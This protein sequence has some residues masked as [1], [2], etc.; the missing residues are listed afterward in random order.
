MIG[1]V[2]ATLKISGFKKLQ[3]DA[4]R[5]AKS[6]DNLAK[7]LDEASAGFKAMGVAA[8][9]AFAGIALG[10][11]K[12]VK[13][14]GEQIR[15]ERSL[16]MAFS[17]LGDGAAAASQE[18]RELAASLQQTTTFGDEATI[19]AAAFLRIQGMTKDQIKNALPVIQDFA[20]VTGQDL[21]RAS[22]LAGRAMTGSVKVLERYIG[23]I[24][25]STAATINSLG[26][27]E[28]AAAVAELLQQKV[29]GQAQVLRQSGVGAMQAYSNAIGDLFEEMGRIIDQPVRD[30]FESSTKS[31]ETMTKALGSL[32]PWAKETLVTVGKFAL[33]FSGAAAAIAAAALALPQMVAGLKMMA[34]AWGVVKA[35]IVAALAPM[36][37]FV[38]VAAVMVTAIAGLRKTWADFGDAFLFHAK[39]MFA[40]VLDVV[41]IW[42]RNVSKFFARVL[43]R[44]LGGIRKMINGLGQLAFA[45]GMEDLAKDIKAF[46]NISFD[47]DLGLL[48]DAAKAASD[49]A[50]TAFT[51]IGDGASSAGN[52]LAKAFGGAFD[53]VKAGFD[54]L[55]KDIAGVL[56]V[57]PMT[58]A[59]TGAAA[60]GAGA[61]RRGAD[62]GAGAG[63][64]KAAAKAR[65]D[66]E[67]LELEA[68]KKNVAAFE[69]RAKQDQMAL[70]AF[71]SNLV[72]RLELEAEA[73]DRLARHIEA[74]DAKLGATVGAI[75]AT[76]Q[77]NL[78]ALATNF[79][80]AL[81]PA[82]Q[83]L[84][85]FGVSLLNASAGGRELQESLKGLFASLAEVVSPVARAFVPLVEALRPIVPVLTQLFNMLLTLSFLE[86]AI[87]IVATVIEVLAG[88]LQTLV[89]AFR[90]L[91]IELLRFVQFITFG[92]I[93]FTR[94][95]AEL[96]A[97]NEALMRPTR[98]AAE[99]MERVAGA[100]DKATQSFE[101][102]NVPSGFKINRAAF[103]A[104]QGIAPGMA[105]DFISR[106]GQAVQRFSPGDTIV[107]FNGDG[108]LGGGGT[109]Y[110]IGEVII[111]G[112]D[113]PEDF[114]EKIS[115]AVRFE[116][117]RG[118]PA[119]P[120]GSQFFG[121]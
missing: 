20:A 80:Q 74:Q 32:S 26:P 107:G 69:A 115:E 110:N 28:K 19:K 89:F 88:I 98:R 22:I 38:G 43:E 1:I 86:P 76:I 11:N 14:F 73:T 91:Y 93:D 66:A 83:A 95:I 62:L 119:L 72:R 70:D 111:Q 78:G 100:A 56:F 40:S 4:K 30:F 42:S 29:G 2:D 12:A 81:S 53:H 9:A 117:Q 102:Y 64:A 10:A 5:A 103:N 108:P 13:A 25:E 45:L 97:A 85:G 52:S 7:D 116:V 114:W 68:R 106:P 84:V 49:I 54:L 15:A 61:A 55:K 96:E 71:G 23:T 67:K 34:V 60:T 113:N 35:K 50:A 59:A 105:N 16:E 109:T 31:V 58:A 77:G 6:I 104:D 21:G 57:D 46:E 65:A 121:V 90:S 82:G 51:S 75:A 47:V 92:A 37:L 33:V 17:G 3:D 36:L 44:I 120:V 101:S 39:E 41:V 87:N 118:G 79:A 94:E 27:Q 24:D 99:N 18:I 8:G 63:A 112:V 48:G